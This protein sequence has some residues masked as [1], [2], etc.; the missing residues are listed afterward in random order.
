MIGISTFCLI[1]EPL[2]PALD[3]L[4]ELTDRI[5][6]MDE[7][8]HHVSD[9]AVLESYTADFSFHAPFHGMNIASVFEPIRRASVG[10]M[11]DCFAVAAEIG[12][13]VVIHPGYFAWRNEQETAAR[14]FGKSCAEL[15]D[16]ARE[17]SAEFSFENM[18]NTNFFNLRT[19][20]D[21]AALSGIP[22]TL[23]V[24]HANLNRCLPA[25]LGT[26]FVH[27]H[28]H[29]NDGRR[30][31]HSPVGEGTID[32]VPVLAAMEH[33][34]ASAVIEVSTF[35]GSVASLRTLEEL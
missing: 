14:Q 8:L 12:A 24:G 19:P 26:P 17:F 35:E 32:F 28:L 27:M 9:P 30:D 5:E 1:E 25:F 13:P 7:G 21:L 22:F 23:D 33:A 10:V 6:I 20:G 31:S 3:R 11:A 16:L 15:R 2:L 18:S 29:D 34:R 4:T